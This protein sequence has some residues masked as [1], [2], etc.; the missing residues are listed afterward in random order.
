MQNQVSARAHVLVARGSDALRW[1]SEVSVAH[2]CWGSLRGAAHAIASCVRALVPGD[3]ILRCQL[4]GWVCRARDELIEGAY[5]LA[6]REPFDRRRVAARVEVDSN[7]NSIAWADSLVEHRS[8]EGRVLNRAGV[9]RMNLGIRVGA[10]QALRIASCRERDRL[11]VEVACDE[12][13]LGHDYSS[14]HA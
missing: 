11:R 9:E 7:L 8:A 10:A 3:C 1:V 12:A 13:V 5:V 4:S 6:C 14:L 2:T